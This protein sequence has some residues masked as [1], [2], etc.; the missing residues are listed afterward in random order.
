[1]SD[2]H[3]NAENEKIRYVAD[4]ADPTAPTDDEINGGTKLDGITK[5]VTGFT[6]TT[7]DK[8]APDMGH[9][10]VSTVAG[11]SKAGSSSL[12]LYRSSTAGD[13]EETAAAALA[14]GTTGYIVF[15]DKPGIDTAVAAADKA[16][17][18]PIEV[19]SNNIKRDGAADDVADRMIEFSITGPPSLRVAVVAGT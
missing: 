8:E 9:R 17:V 7:D 14:E 3:I 5:G 4:M 12:D 18:W 2:R 16:D 10:F 11:M 13:L 15:Y 1:M 6:K 19:R